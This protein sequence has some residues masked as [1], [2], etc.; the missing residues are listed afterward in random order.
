MKWYKE[1]KG[2]DLRVRAKSTGK[3]IPLRDLVTVLPVEYYKKVLDEGAKYPARI[4]FRYLGSMEL[5]ESTK[6]DGKPR[7]VPDGNGGYKKVISDYFDR[8][9]NYIYIFS[10]QRTKIRVEL[11]D[12]LRSDKIGTAHK[13]AVK[14]A[15]K[16]HPKGKFYKQV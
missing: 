8:Y 5:L 14:I 13:R 11:R 3:V 16:E 1:V 7:P 2:K 10:I 9:L 4:R 15:Y 6:I 12:I